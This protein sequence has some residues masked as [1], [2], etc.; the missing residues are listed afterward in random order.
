MQALRQ[1]LQQKNIAASM[2]VI[3]AFSPN[4][5][6]FSN[7][8]QSPAPPDTRPITLPIILYHHIRPITSDMSTL[9]RGLSVTPESFEDQLRY[10][11]KNNYTTLPLQQLAKALENK[12]SI[13]SKTFALTFDDGYADLY[14][15]AWPLL[16]RYGFQATAFI[17]VNRVGTPDYASWD[18]LREMER[19]GAIDIQSHTLNHPMLATLSPDRARYEIEQSKVI[20][21]KKLHKSISIFCYPYGNYNEG[22]LRFVRQAGYAAALTTKG[23]V[24]HAKD[25]LFELYRVRLSTG[26][27]DHRLART[28]RSLFGQKTP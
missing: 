25:S 11:K 6:S 15:Y 27:K 4:A 8:K 16:K 2:I 17:I 26:D 22:V 12:S 13:P 9:A 1:K 21:E 3:I 7:A 23:G 19:S 28:I 14:T 20:L 5:L 18:Q 24:Q 10:F